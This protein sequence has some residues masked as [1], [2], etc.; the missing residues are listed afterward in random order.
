MPVS[1][2]G[3]C[4]ALSRI[5]EPRL[6]ELD[7][8]GD[9]DRRMLL[10]EFNE[11]AA[12]FPDVRVHELFAQRVGETPD[13]IA[14]TD[15]RDSLS[16]AVLDARANQL[17]HAL[18]RAGIGAATWSGSARIARSRWSSACSGF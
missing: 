3:C 10:K 18:R 9:D 5:R 13:A 2:S 8:L 17:A 11:T 15:G 4:A 12:E 6:G 7:L 16:Y 1:S 14:V